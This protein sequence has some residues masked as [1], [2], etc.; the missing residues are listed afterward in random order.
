MSA[1]TFG[2]LKNAKIV[3]VQDV[4]TSTISLVIISF[5]SFSTFERVFNF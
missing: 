4:D 2:A 1:L 5:F 3:R